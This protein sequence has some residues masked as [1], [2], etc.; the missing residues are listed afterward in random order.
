M[1]KAPETVSP[2]PASCLIRCAAKK[3]RCQSFLCAVSASPVRSLGIL[4]VPTSVPRRRPRPGRR[5]SSKDC[6][7]SGCSGVVAGGAPRSRVRWRASNRTARW[8]PDPCGVTG[9]P[10]TDEPGDR[11]QAGPP[12]PGQRPS[13]REER[14]GPDS[15]R[16]RHRPLASTS[17]PSASR[18]PCTSSSSATGFDAPFVTSPGAGSGAYPEPRTRLSRPRPSLW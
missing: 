10:G 15:R 18:R 17:S 1:A 16:A 11:R 3:P 7:P 9:R 13:P 5:S 4:C 6:E 14:T 2:S 12:E 8:P